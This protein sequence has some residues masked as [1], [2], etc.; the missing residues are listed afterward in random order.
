VKLAA[1]VQGIMTLPRRA[2]LGGAA[3]ALSGGAAMAAMS[4]VGAR[5]AVRPVPAVAP[6]PATPAAPAGADVAPGVPATARAAGEPR[7]FWPETRDE[8]VVLEV[9]SQGC[10]GDAGT[11]RFEIRGEEPGVVR[12]LDPGT[13][14]VLREIALDAQMRAE[15][16]RTIAFYRAPPGDVVCSTVD[17]VRVAFRQGGRDVWSETYEDSTCETE[18]RG[19][20]WS[21]AA[22]FDAERRAGTDE[23]MARAPVE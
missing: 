1:I 4:G 3:V 2:W 16:G 6:A 23:R 8:S 9:S 18:Y 17:V 19:A 11:Q 7:R 21:L 12:A 5:E 20:P 14:A 13:G 10:F 22:L 15:L